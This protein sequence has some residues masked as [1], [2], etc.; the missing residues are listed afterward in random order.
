MQTPR[1]PSFRLCAERAKTQSTRGSQA[2]SLVDLAVTRYPTIRVSKRTA[3]PLVLVAQVRHELRRAGV[4]HDEIGRFTAE[5]LSEGDPEHARTVCS[6]WVE[7]G[8]RDQA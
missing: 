1:H 2:T 4:A 5:A 8:A 7:T 6:R 3:N